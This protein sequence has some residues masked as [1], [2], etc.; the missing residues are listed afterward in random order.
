MTLKHWWQRHWEMELEFVSLQACFV[1]L[2]M[3]Y[4]ETYVYSFRRVDAGVGWNGL[5]EFL[6]VVLIQGHT[7]SLIAQ[8]GLK[9]DKG[10][11]K[12]LI[13]PFSPPRWLGSHACVSP[14]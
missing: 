11:Y 1:T 6:F 10:D 13:L 5:L 8:V 14:P 3:I 4:L 9:L 2:N 7:W 12:L